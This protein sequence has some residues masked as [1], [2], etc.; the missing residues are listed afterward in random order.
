[1]WCGS[2]N[3]W[4]DRRWDNDERSY[5]VGKRRAFGR[6]TQGITWDSGTIM[7]VVAKEW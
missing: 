7:E 4:E 2:K 3:A 6:M 5:V 1:M